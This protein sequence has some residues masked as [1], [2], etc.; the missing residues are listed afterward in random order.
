MLHDLCTVQ[1]LLTHFDV[2]NWKR[3]FLLCTPHVE[4]SASKNISIMYV[5]L[6]RRKTHRF[7]VTDRQ[8]MTVSTLEDNFPFIQSPS[9][10]LFQVTFRETLTLTHDVLYL[11]KEKLLIHTRSKWWCILRKISSST[12]LMFAF[13]TNHSMITAFANHSWPLHMSKPYFLLLSC[14]GIF[15]LIAL[16]WS[17]EF[18]NKEGVCARA[19]IQGGGWSARCLLKQ[20]LI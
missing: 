20:D 14:W 9:A 2:Q 5:T 15:S 12:L 13:F 19:W 1:Q 8:Y 7:D 4:I 11:G 6:E 16:Q 3:L 17:I 18:R 10:E